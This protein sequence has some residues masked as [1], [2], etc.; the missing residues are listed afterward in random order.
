MLRIKRVTGIVCK[1]LSR[2]IEGHEHHGKPTKNI[3]QGEAA[4]M[5]LDDPRG[6]GV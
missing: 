1:E 5:F 2:V 6:G 4:S 3:H